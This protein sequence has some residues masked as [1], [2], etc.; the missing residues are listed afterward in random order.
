LPS[1]SL[2]HTPVPSGTDFSEH[3]TRLDQR[4]QRRR[5]DTD[6]VHDADVRKLA[7]LAQLV[8]GARRSAQ[9]L[10]DLAESPVALERWK[11]GEPLAYKR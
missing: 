8:D 11:R 6:G 1:G 4:D 9:V 7:L 3:P 2:P 5:F 10:G